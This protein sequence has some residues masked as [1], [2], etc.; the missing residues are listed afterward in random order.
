MRGGFLYV[1]ENKEHYSQ[2]F[3]LISEIKLTFLELF[4]EKYQHSDL[5][6][7]LS[8]QTT[9]FIATA[10]HHLAYNKGDTP[11]SLST[12]RTGGSFY[13]PRA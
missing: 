7:L 10:N 8:W 9:P 13:S 1:Q 4:S 3:L 6:P 2:P 12:M 11:P 5:T